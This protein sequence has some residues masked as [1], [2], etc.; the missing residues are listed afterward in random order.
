MIT[1]LFEIDHMEF[2]KWIAAKE[3]DCLENKMRDRIYEHKK[4]NSL[5]YKTSANLSH[6][7]TNLLREILNELELE[8][9][10]TLKDTPPK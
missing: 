6:L 4:R 3:P 8:Y 5:L 10:Q 7:R 9:I 1:E 2:M